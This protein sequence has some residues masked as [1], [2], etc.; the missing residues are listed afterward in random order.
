M[1]LLSQ[2][3]RITPQSTFR[4]WNVKDWLKRTFSTSRGFMSSFAAHKTPTPQFIEM[5]R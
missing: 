1:Q 4:Q 2:L 5:M 3:Y